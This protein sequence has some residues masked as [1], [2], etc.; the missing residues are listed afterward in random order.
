[1]RREAK[2]ARESGREA[3]RP[4]DKAWMTRITRR[5]L[6]A[7]LAAT[8]GPPVTSSPAVAQ[9]QKPPP[10]NPAP[11]VA[12]G[13]RFTYQEVVERA[14]R[15][16]EQPFQEA[17][18]WRLP[19][20]FDKLDYD[21]WREI[22]FKPE[23]AMLVSAG[24]PFRLE[25]FHLGFLYRRPVTINL[26]RDGIAAP[27]P[28]STTLFDYGRLKLDQTPP[29]NFGFAGFRLHYPL[30]D[31]HVND[32]VISF[33]GASY[34]RF[35]GREQRYGLSARAL[36]VEAGTENE[37]FPF[38]REFWIETPGARENRAT[39]Y[40][41]IDG[42]AAT[43]AFRFDLTPGQDS[44]LEVQATLF[45]RLAGVKF[46]FA[47]LTSMFLGGEN[48]HRVN[49]GFRAELHELRRT[50]DAHGHGRMALAAALQSDPCA[51]HLVHG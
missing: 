42:K 40:G 39:I 44:E 28:Y 29:V 6:L 23:Q 14:K 8:A 32:E 5:K 41:L 46:G 43:G 31:P 7:A 16:A 2:C 1:M 17:A 15:L 10:S 26:I 3:R 49:P 12:K 38:F 34:F 18:S 20:A 21:A 19:A 30:N 47:P 45:P 24:G 37:S 11:E 51:H 22:R 9:T 4:R 48:D 50:A 13:P 33:L 35:L 25:T 27:I 36:C